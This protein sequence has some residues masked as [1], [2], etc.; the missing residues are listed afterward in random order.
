MTITRGNK[1]VFLGMHIR[2]VKANGTAEITMRDYLEESI[3][4]SGM[5]ITMTV[6]SPAKRDLFEVEENAPLLE[7][8]GSDAFHRVTAKLLYAALRA[9]GDILT[10]FSFLSTR[11]SK[12]TTQDQ[13][14]LKRLL[15]YIK[16]RHVTLQIYIQS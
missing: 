8:T 6:A 2:Y 5:N 10:S 11:V 7:R 12:S 15:E 9:R 3:A 13:A 1:H 16:G 14:K 4:E